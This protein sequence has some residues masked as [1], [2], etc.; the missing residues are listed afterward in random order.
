MAQRVHGWSTLGELRF[1]TEMTL[2]RQDA[3]TV[4]KA[5]K[6]APTVPSRL[7]SSL[8]ASCG[9]RGLRAVPRHVIGV[10][11]LESGKHMGFSNG[12]RTVGPFGIW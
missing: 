11:A 12:N 3:V 4:L 8:R 7:L 6:N 10:A 2:G 1:V 9:P 5:C